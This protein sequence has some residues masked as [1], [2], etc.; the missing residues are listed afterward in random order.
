MSEEPYSFLEEKIKE[1]TFNIKKIGN[2]ALQMIALGLI[3]GLAT[4]VGFFMLKPWAEST[5]RGDPQEIQ[6]PDDEDV[7]AQEQRNQELQNNQQELTVEDYEMLHVS[8]G[9]VAD[10]AAKS[11]VYVSGSGEETVGSAGVIVADNGQELLMVVNVFGFENVKDCSV[12][13]ADDRVYPGTMKQYSKKLHIGIVS[14]NK[15]VVDEATSAAIQVAELGNSNILSSGTT[16]MGLGNLYGYE[17]G[18]AY[19]IASSVN[20]SV[21]FADGDYSILVTDIAGSANSNGVL[22]DIEGNVVGIIANKVAEK[23]QDSVLTAYGISTLKREIE[24]MSNGKGV[25]YIGIIG[26]VVTEKISAEKGIPRGLYVTEVEEESPAMSAGIQ[27]GDIIT[28]IGGEE[29]LS[30]ASY[31]NA[32]ITKEI[33]DSVRLKGQRMGAENYVDIDFDVTIDKK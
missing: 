9:Q 33:G 15:A 16:L 7:I 30:L 29:I 28:S 6:I 11:M 12:K 25:P 8:I 4:C 10:V 1:D 19:G 24:L 31:R 21:Y 3:F 13:F 26:T 14:V 2:K 18:T 27:S 5:F 23:T 20:Q 17:D 32:L 22:F